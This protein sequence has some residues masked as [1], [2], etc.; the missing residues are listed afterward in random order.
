MAAT[1]NIDYTK[2]KPTKRE[3]TS[4]GE[5]DHEKVTFEIEDCEVIGEQSSRWRSGKELAKRALKKIK[6]NSR[7][8]IDF[9]SLNW[10]K[11]LIVILLLTLITA[12]F[13]VTI[14]KVY[15]IESTLKEQNF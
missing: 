12:L 13:I 15:S 8:L 7:Q 6:Q 11:W 14:V 4:D 2:L 1:V 10:L 3:K 9:L 5:L